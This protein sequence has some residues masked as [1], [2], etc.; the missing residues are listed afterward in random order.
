MSRM[1]AGNGEV[2]GQRSRRAWWLLGAAIAFEVTATLSLKGALAIPALYAV[3]VVGYVAAFVCLSRVLRAGMPLGVAYGV[4][5]AA[6]VALTAGLSMLIFDEPVT[7]LMA[8]G[9]ALV[10]G[11]VLCVEL[12]ASARWLAS[13]RPSETT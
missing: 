6:G 5:S 12:G 8:C 11:G 1:D 7:V 3:V 2:V 13:R 4:W 10:V 9:M